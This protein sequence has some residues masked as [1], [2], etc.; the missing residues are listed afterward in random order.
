MS[1]KHQPSY[2]YAV[3]QGKHSLQDCIFLNWRQCQLFI[4][5]ENEED[6]Q[7][8][9]FS[10]FNDIQDAV[11]YLL[12]NKNA[13]STNESKEK[14]TLP[15]E[16]SNKKPST[17]ATASL[18]ILVE[19]ATSA[20]P[21]K[22]KTTTSSAK[23]LSAAS[24]AKPDK[25]P[26]AKT[27][28]GKAKPSADQ[29]DQSKPAGNPEATAKTA[30]GK[31][32]TK[33]AET[34]MS[35]EPTT[36]RRGR[37]PNTVNA[38]SEEPAQK[39]KR[40][41]PRKDAESTSQA[42]AKTAN[43][44]RKNPP[45]PIAE[46]LKKQT[47]TPIRTKWWSTFNLLKEHYKAN[48]GADPSESEQ[49]ELFNFVRI[50]RKKYRT[51]VLN[52]T[53]TRLNEDEI[54]YLESI[55]FDF[56]FNEVVWDK[57]FE[58]LKRY[59]QK[60]K[61]EYPSEKTA[62]GKWA[63]L[64]KL[65]YR[66]KS[67]LSKGQI[68]L[69]RSIDFPN[70]WNQQF[71]ALKE[72]YESN[73]N[74]HPKG[75]TDLGKWTNAQKKRFKML[76][77]HPGNPSFNYLS[78]EQMASLETVG[79]QKPDS[80]S[81]YAPPSYSWYEMYE[82]LKRYKEQHGTC[83][84]PPEKEAD[85]PNLIKFIQNQRR[86]YR[87]RQLDFQKSLSDKKLKLLQEIGFDFQ[88]VS[89]D[90]LYMQLETYCKDHGGNSKDMPKDHPLYKWVNQQNYQAK[91][92]Y[93]DP[94][95]SQLTEP[96]VKRLE[97]IG[98][99]EDTS[100][101]REEEYEKMFTEKFKELQAYKEEHGDLNLTAKHTE[102]R[103]FCR[104]QRTYYVKLKEGKKSPMTA[105][106]EKQLTDLGFQFYSVP[107]DIPSW[108][109]GLVFLQKLQEQENG[110]GQVNNTNT[111]E[112]MVLWLHYYAK[113]REKQQQGK[114]ATISRE[115]VSALDALEGVIDWANLPTPFNEQS[116]EYK[117]EE[118]RKFR[119]EHRHTMIP[120]DRIGLNMWV[121]KLREK[122]KKGALDQSHIIQLTSIGFS[123]QGK[124]LQPQGTRMSPSEDAQEFEEM[125]PKF[126]QHMAKTGIFSISKKL[127]KVDPKLSKWLQKQKTH[128]KRLKLGQ[129]TTMTAERII[130]L[131]EA[132]F[133]FP[134]KREYDSFER[135]FKMLSEFQKEHGHLRVKHT[136]PIIGQWLSR[137]RYE[138]RKFMEGKESTLTADNI[139]Q[140]N[141]LGM[142]WE[143]PRGRMKLTVRTKDGDFVNEFG[144][145]HR[146]GKAFTPE[147]NEEIKTIYRRLKAE[148]A[149]GY[150]SSRAL[151]IEAKC[152]KDYAMR[153]I[154]E[155]EAELK[156]AP[157]GAVETEDD[158][159]G[160]SAD[161]N[162]FETPI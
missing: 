28:V 139:Q 65:R 48:N 20:E 89:W 26:P 39:K 91:H 98:V 6:D 103:N 115:Q 69:L 97:A 80:N 9:E 27:E 74:E 112:E 72:Y 35:T 11:Q 73:N 54:R 140:L 60:N 162:L 85:H 105:E 153:L 53:G 82:I 25:S 34:G 83:D 120:K 146:P 2:F 62:L 92:F 37:L 71:E 106:R 128:Y 49:P 152:S 144:G 129:P 123:F 1:S 157:L 18:K 30:T 47:R 14:G 118:L 122:Y 67:N 100:R 160:V 141:E 10:P 135:K 95:K 17:A 61:C 58:L 94:Q 137:Q 86:A 113:E 161:E 24:A 32:Q 159:T 55:K 151:G 78:K 8:C 13:T 154:K 142:I 102:L 138:Y 126:Q 124:E 19:A 4:T 57:Q 101:K 23:L 155:V 133:I 88:F 132:G 125:F 31:P 3:R 41:R 143:T 81:Y 121:A 59:Y 93:D 107:N 99:C 63:N 16:S 116:W 127:T 40:G 158:L 50:Q 66:L 70:G 77:T 90:D 52:L 117:L 109:R 136:V 38:T 22:E 108:E 21:H 111:T 29:D 51:M 44:K 45:M 12:D 119:E 56:Q 150:V 68:A 134:K 87:A 36:G 42:Q 15:A 64:Q 43:L 76:Y 75:D 145:F 84:V 131:T 104:L 149:G 46:P 147:R 79:F 110:S 33:A 130:K 96:Q 148:A 5:D 114:F 156:A 7:P